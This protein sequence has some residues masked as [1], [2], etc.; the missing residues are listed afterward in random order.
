MFP[1]ACFAE[2]SV[3]GVITSSNSFVT[4]HLA[5]RLNSVL[6]TVEFPTGIAN[7][8]TG[9]TDVNGNALS[10]CGKGDRRSRV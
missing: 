9:L 5:I 7:L 10:H 4:R 6:E 2:E 1:S 3:E 8:N